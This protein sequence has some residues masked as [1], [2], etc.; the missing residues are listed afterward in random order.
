MLLFTIKSILIIKA[1]FHLLFFIYKYYF[2]GYIPERLQT[3]WTDVYDFQDL[4]Q[5]KFPG[6]YLL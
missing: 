1:A 3:N 4:V 2:S 5:G 6:I